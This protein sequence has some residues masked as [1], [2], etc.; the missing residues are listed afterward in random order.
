MC[1]RD[2]QRILVLRLDVV[3][4]VP[5]GYADLLRD[6]VGGVDRA[7]LVAA[8]H[9]ESAPNPGQRVLHDLDERVLP[10]AGDPAHVQLAAA[11]DAVDEGALADCA[12]ED[13]VA[14]RRDVRDGGLDPG[15]ALDVAL[16]VADD[17][18]HARVV[19]RAHDEQRGVAGRDERE[20]AGPVSYTH[21]TLPTILRV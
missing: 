18:D 3:P 14:V 1:I 11:H 12:D 10:P 19:A 8:G 20:P 9:H 17:A 21:L 4:P 15:D 2:R 5:G 7:A 13:D 16:E 6:G